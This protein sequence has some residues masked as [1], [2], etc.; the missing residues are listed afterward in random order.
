M[1]DQICV[2]SKINDMGSM[3]VEKMFLLQV[4]PIVTTK[5]KDEEGASQETS[6]SSLNLID[7]RKRLDKLKTKM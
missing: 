5:S 7:V 2:C 1:S 3:L 4:P 6:S